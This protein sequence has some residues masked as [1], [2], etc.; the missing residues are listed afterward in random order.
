[1]QNAPAHETDSRQDDD[2][3]YRQQCLLYAAFV[4]MEGCI[5]I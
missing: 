4:S 5:H 3:D 2:N 1:M